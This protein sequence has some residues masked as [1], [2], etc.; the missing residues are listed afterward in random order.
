MRLPGGAIAGWV[1]GIPEYGGHVL[2]LHPLVGAPDLQARHRPGA[3]ADLE[4]Q[5]AAR[6]IQTL[7]LGTDD[8]TNRTGQ[9]AG[10]DLYPDVWP[11]IAAIRN[12]RGHPYVSST[13]NAA[14]RSS[15]CCPTPMAAAGPISSYQARRR[16]P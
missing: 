3:V 6:G 4:R 12:L 5:A 16:L 13:G 15:G 8:E 7:F 10:A 14:L 1:G 11:H 2:Q 9:F